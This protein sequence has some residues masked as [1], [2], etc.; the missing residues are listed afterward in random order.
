ML[1]RGGYDLSSPRAADLALDTTP[2]GTEPC[3]LGAGV[4]SPTSQ[5]STDTRTPA[6]LSSGGASSGSTPRKSAAPG[7]STAPAVLWRGAAGGSAALPEMPPL[8]LTAPAAVWR[9]ADALERPPFRLL[10]EVAPAAGTLQRG[11]EWSARARRLQSHAFVD[12]ECGSDEDR[13]DR[14]VTSAAAA[15]VP[16]KDS[17]DT[18]RAGEAEEIQQMVAASEMIMAAGAGSQSGLASHV[19]AMIDVAMGEHPHPGAAVRTTNQGHTK[20]GLQGSDHGSSCLSQEDAQKVVQQSRLWEVGKLGPVGVVRSYSMPPAATSV[21]SSSSLRSGRNEA[22]VVAVSAA[23]GAAGAVGAS[24]HVYSG[25]F[26]MGRDEFILY[27]S[28]SEHRSGP[29]LAPAAGTH[30]GMDTT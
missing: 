28:G 23:D 21:W 2:R 16:H 17:G 8:P 30:R 1:L 14:Q 18:L 26:D 24:V 29:E 11:Q 3:A 22:G 13:A 12:D 4:G 5:A 15:A 20:P 27:S 19:D 25:V 7:G 6:Y 10:T 9:R